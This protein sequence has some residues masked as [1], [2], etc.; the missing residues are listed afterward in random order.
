MQNLQPAGGPERRTF[1]SFYES[2]RGTQA[3]AFEVNCGCRQ[4][5]VLL[6]I[7]GLGGC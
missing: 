2:G 3:K 1:N 5:D 4:L 7:A 6:A